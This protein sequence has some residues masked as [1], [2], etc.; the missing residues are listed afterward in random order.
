M[1][2]TRSD[3]LRAAAALSFPLSVCLCLAASP[4]G[5]Q[6]VIEASE[7]PLPL[8]QAGSWEGSP[9]RNFE[10][11]QAVLPGRVLLS[12]EAEGRA[13]SGALAV[14]LRRLSV[15]LFEKQGWRSPFSEGDPLHVYVAR[16]EAGGVRRLGVRGI[17]NGRLTRPM[18]QLDATG[19][20]DQEIVQEV[21]R[22]FAY[23]VLSAY[24]A[25]DTSF[26]TAAA[27]DYI[28]IDRRLAWEGFSSRKLP[29]PQGVRPDC[30]RRGS[31]RGKRARKS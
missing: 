9:Y 1:R 26:F 25:P 2:M 18:I 27:A 5:A 13:L 14:E 24:E 17:E 28:A 23:A 31:A 10:A 12:D 29:A 3:G 6:A 16:K 4:A 21:G 7:R 20:S 11:A 8:A 19:L 30:A 15:E 22:L